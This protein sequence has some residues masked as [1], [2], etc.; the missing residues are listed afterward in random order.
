MPLSVSCLWRYLLKMAKDPKSR[1]LVQLTDPFGEMPV[2]D[3]QKIIKEI[4]VKRPTRSSRC[5]IF[6]PAALAHGISSAE[7]P[8]FAPFDSRGIVKQSTKVRIAQDRIGRR[9]ARVGERFA[10]RFI[11]GNK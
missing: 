7:S 8:W 11:E 9:A 4:G 10:H 1:E 3:R 6:S 5:P 2:A